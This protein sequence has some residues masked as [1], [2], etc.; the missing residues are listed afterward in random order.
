MNK[1]KKSDSTAEQEILVDQKNFG[2]WIVLHARIILNSEIPFQ[3]I[4]IM[5]MLKK[6]GY[7]LCKLGFNI[8]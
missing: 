7:N 2:N 8:P 4:V 5:L 3:H 6:K 1:F